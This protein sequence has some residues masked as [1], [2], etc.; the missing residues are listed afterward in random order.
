ME[1]S[2]DRPAG[3]APIIFRTGGKGFVWFLP[4]LN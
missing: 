3:V 2:R 1:L 4:E